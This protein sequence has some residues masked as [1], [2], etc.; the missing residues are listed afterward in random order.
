MKKNLITPMFRNY[1]SRF[2]IL[3][4]CILFFMPSPANAAYKRMD[5]MDDNGI[6]IRI[7][8]M[9]QFL[10]ALENSGL[11]QLWNS[12]RMKGFLNNQSLADT[13]KTTLMKEVVDSFGN[14][15]IPSNRRKELEHLMWEQC[16]AFKSE[17]ILSIQP[18]PGETAH[19]AFLTAMNDDEYE[20][21]SKIAQRLE[22][23][24]ADFNFVTKRKNFQG[25]EILTSLQKVADG[26]PIL[27]GYE[28]Y[29]NGTYLNSR[30]LEWL[31][32]CIARL[33]KEKPVKA[34]TPP[35]L[36]IEASPSFWE[37]L[38]KEL[39]NPYTPAQSDDTPT[40]PTI[41]PT[42]VMLKAL[43]LE[44]LKSV[45]FK[46]IFHADRTEFF[47]DLLQLPGKQ[48]SPRGFW[49]LLSAIPVPRDHRLAY[50][51]EDVYSYTVAQ[52]DFNNLWNELLHMSDRMNPK[53]S[54]QFKQSIAMVEGLMQ[55]N[56]SRDLFGNL[57]TL[58]T[59][60]SRM[61]GI[62]KQELVAQQLKDPLLTQKLLAKVFGEGSMLHAQLQGMLEVHD[63]QG[64]KLYSLDPSK[65][66][67]FAAQNQ[68]NPAAQS[69]NYGIAVVDGAL[70]VGA[71]KL[72]RGIIQASGDKSQT[73]RFYLSDDYKNMIKN[74]PGNATGFTLLDMGR[75]I[76]PFLESIK[77]PIFLEALKPGFTLND[78]ES[79]DED[80]KDSSS[81]EFFMENLKYD[82]L[83][84][85][86]FM[87]SFFGKSISYT[88]V[89]NG[90]FSAHGTINNPK[91]KQ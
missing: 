56:F 58:Y 79:E 62:M 19:F 7:S 18:S 68:N 67:A 36:Q 81:M 47:I 71:E 88:Q 90:N 41:S 29:C 13:L 12:P 55:I 77:N 16:K 35:T 53:G 37:Q 49:G 25:V 27:H 38:F 76:I 10:Q 21:F 51:P 15:D 1:L 75:L 33:H 23:L 82:L 66:P 31:E 73:N 42:A 50:V 34:D 20:R 59:N 3:L 43:G 48:D 65:S 24:M 52:L 86:E 28:A 30:N 5:L 2:Y 60:Y 70:I 57:G 54:N 74:L 14:A 26:E 17:F 46:T 78:P 6:I 85:V 61:E 9:S 91:K 80:N 69:P 83:P 64:H 22:E 39:D 32:R 63:L 4:L 72:V 45:S 87:S 11:G 40:P 44:R 89:K 8:K 84:S